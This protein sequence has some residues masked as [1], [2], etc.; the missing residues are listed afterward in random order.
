MSRGGDALARLLGSLGGSKV[1]IQQADALIDG[2][3]QPRVSALAS[4][5]GQQVTTS[6]LFYESHLAQWVRG[7][8]PLARLHAEPQAG[9][10]ASGHDRNAG[11]DSAP[12]AGGTSDRAGAAVDPRLAAVVRQQA[13]ML[14]S[15][16]FQWQGQAWPGVPMR[17]QI[18]ERSNET[19]DTSDER[20]TH[21]TSLSL[22]LAGLGTFE[23]RLSVGEDRV[24]IAAWAEDGPGRNLLAADLKTLRNRLQ[25]AGF[26]EPTVHLLTEPG[27]ER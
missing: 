24:R 6:G 18:Q 22:E 8:Y 19:G 23:A 16:V 9:L 21:T 25:Q 5:L 17:W 20:L 4:L 13:E 26:S 11:T 10:G 1:G 2:L 7:R 3:Q 15:G 27:H 14:A 12:G